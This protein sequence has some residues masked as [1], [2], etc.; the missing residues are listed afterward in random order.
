MIIRVILMLT[1]TI[2]MQAVLKLPLHLYLKSGLEKGTEEWKQ[3]LE[4]VIRM[5]EMM[6]YMCGMHRDDAIITVE[7]DVDGYGHVEIGKQLSYTAVYGEAGQTY[8]RERCLRDLW[9]YCSGDTQQRIMEWELQQDKD[10]AMLCKIFGVENVKAAEE[11]E[12]AEKEGN[13]NS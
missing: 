8:P 9:V 4:Y 11:A 12:K 3:E 10:Y 5:G 1:M 7:G 2:D 6:V 13:V